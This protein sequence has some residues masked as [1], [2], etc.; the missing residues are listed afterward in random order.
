[1]RSVAEPY[2]FTG[3]GII[4]PGSIRNAAKQRRFNG[5]KSYASTV[6]VQF[7]FT[8]IGITRRSITRSVRGTTSGV[9]FAVA[10]CELIGIGIIPP[11]CIKNVGRKRQL[12]GTRE[13]V[14]TADVQ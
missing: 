2:E 13:H 1:V 8:V 5:M 10:P 9:R 4:H 14:S 6:G 7:G 11:R 3:I 12:S